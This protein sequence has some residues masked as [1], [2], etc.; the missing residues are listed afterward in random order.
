MDLHPTANVVSG[1]I[2]AHNIK[3]INGEGPKGDCLLVLVVPCAAQLARVVIDLLNIWIVLDHNGILEVGS[4]SGVAAHSIESV[5]C[6]SLG[7]T[8][9]YAYIKVSLLLVAIL[10]HVDTLVV[11]VVALAEDN[12]VENFVEFNANLH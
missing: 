3:H 2:G 4:A 5:L 11:T 9:V 6:V 10:V 8:G 12:S 7:A 1:K